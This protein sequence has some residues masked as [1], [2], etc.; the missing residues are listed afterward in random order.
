MR[1]SASPDLFP[2][3]IETSR[4]R[5]GWPDKPTPS[6]WKL[7]PLTRHFTI[8]NVRGIGAEPLTKSIC[9]LSSSHFTIQN[10]RG[11]K[12]WRARWICTHKSFHDPKC[13]PLT[14]PVTKTIFTQAQVNCWKQRIEALALHYQ[15][16]AAYIV[17][18]IYTNVRS[19]QHVNVNES[20]RSS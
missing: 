1:G 15:Y 13:T 14:N 7:F 16:Y 10:A 8:Q 5:V 17:S 2:E 9:A 18:N 20:W 19:V 11:E 6:S 12:F 3:L 4:W